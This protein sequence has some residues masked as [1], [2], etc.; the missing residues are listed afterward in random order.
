MIG[1][2]QLH[3]LGGRRVDHEPDVQVAQVRQ[4]F[5][6]QHRPLH[7][8]VRGDDEGE[9]LCR[10]TDVVQDF[11]HEARDTWSREEA[12]RDVHVQLVLVAVPPI[13]RDRV[14][15]RVPQDRQVEGEADA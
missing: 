5:A 3:P 14:G 10:Q 8:Q 2:R 6:H 15:G 9:P 1:G 7:D 13:E 12:G 11:A 4:R